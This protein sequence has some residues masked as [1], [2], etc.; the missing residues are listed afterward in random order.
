MCLC[1]CLSQYSWL[2]LLVLS[3]DIAARWEGIGPPFKGLQYARHF[4]RTLVGVFIIRSNE[5]LAHHEA[6]EGS[7][8]MT[9]AAVLR[10]NRLRNAESST[11]ADPLSFVFC[12]NHVLCACLSSTRPSPV[13]LLLLLL[14][15]F[16]LS[17]APR[18]RLPY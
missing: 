11:L 4:P 14:Y 8:M 17:Q 6:T 12:V 15:C 18:T 13:L 9:P 10:E 5:T 2:L 1:V 3:H 16:F 7:A